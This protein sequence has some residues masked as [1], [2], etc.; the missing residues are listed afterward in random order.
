MPISARQS[1]EA[2]LLHPDFED[3]TTLANVKVDLRYGSKQNL[4]GRDVYGGFQRALLHKLAA[5]KFRAASSILAL[6]HPSLKFIVFDALRPQAAQI[7]FWELVKDTPQRI[8]FAD[9]ANG[10]VH[11]YG[12][13]LDL[14][15]VD[16]AGRE[17]DMATGF[18]DLSDLAQPRLEED[19]LRQGLL[20]PAQIANRKILRAVMEEVGFLQLPH[21]WWH[22]DALP[23]AVVRASYQRCE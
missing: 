1:L 22:Y 13:A 21:E 10:S 12:F 20:S 6:R 5:K 2:A 4:L 11:S 3:V 8:Y 17:L 23:G 14:G 7:A 19:F 18:D 16:A 9:P 15:L